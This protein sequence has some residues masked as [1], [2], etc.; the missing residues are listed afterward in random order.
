MQIVHDPVERRQVD[1]LDDAHVVQRDVEIC[2]ASVRSLPPLKPVQPNVVRPWRLA[3]STAR[4]M[5]GLLPEPLMAMS[6]S[7][8]PARF[9][10]CSTKT[11]SKPSSLPQARMYGVLSVRL[12]MRKRFFV[13]VVEVLAAQRALADVLAEVGGVGAAAAVADHENETVAL[14]TGIHGVRQGL[15]L[16][17]VDAEQLLADALQKRT[18]VQFGS[19]HVV[20]LRWRVGAY[21]TN[22]LRGRPDGLVQWPGPLPFQTRR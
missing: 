6:R 5:F 15:D 7:P 20:L 18:N 22:S 11:R 17:G 12:R 4:K 3:H 2:W 14:V 10:S 1:R 13:V 19:E 8:G 9:L 16:G 21:F